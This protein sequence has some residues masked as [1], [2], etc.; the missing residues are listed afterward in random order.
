VQQAVN[1]LG[2]VPGQ[3]V[4]RR[5]QRPLPSRDH[6][7]LRFYNVMAACKMVCEGSLTDFLNL[8]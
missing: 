6:S 4:A 2:Q 5:C 8:V 3:T 7:C 1:T